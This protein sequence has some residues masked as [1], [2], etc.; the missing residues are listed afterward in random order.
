MHMH[1]Q[2]MV[3][4]WKLEDNLQESILAFQH[5]ASVDRTQVIRLSQ[6]HVPFAHLVGPLEYTSVEII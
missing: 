2:D 3:C 5:V 1:R 6:L 4:L